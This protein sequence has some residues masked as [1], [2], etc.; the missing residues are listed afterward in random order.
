MGPPLILTAFLLIFVFSKAYKRICI[1]LILVVWV[2]AL[3]DTLSFINSYYGAGF[4]FIWE[5]SANGVS[6]N[7]IAAQFGLATFQTG[8]FVLEE[9]LTWGFVAFF[10]VIVGSIYLFLTCLMRKGG[11]LS[12]RM[13]SVTFTKKMGNPLTAAFDFESMQTYLIIGLVTMPS[14]IS[15]FISFS[16][17]SVFVQ[18][19][20][21]YVLLFYRFSLMA[22]TRL[23]KKADLH[24][25]KEDIGA[26][27]GKRVFSWFTQLNLLISIGL[28]GYTFLATTVDP[29]VLTAVT[30]QELRS[31]LVAILVL[32]F[33]EGFAVFFFSRFWH[34]WSRLRTRLS[35][36][37]VKGALYSLWRGMLIGGACFIL[38]YSMLSFVTAAT[39]F[40]SVGT[41]DPIF[42][43]EQGSYA[44]YKYM[45]DVY[46]HATHPLYAVLLLP[47][48]WSL[49]ALFLFQFIKVLIGG[50]L[51][52]RRNVA[53]EYSIVV[54]SLVMVILLWTVMP[55]TNF[56]LGTYSTGL[57]SDF[58][59]T[60]TQILV[61]FPL[62][63]SV[64]T[65]YYFV[66]A[67]TDILYIVF[68]D[69]PI[70]VFG[71]L[72]FAYFFEFRRDVTR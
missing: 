19:V 54:S 70:W 64:A 69:L 14:M 68:L 59:A 66:L 42:N 43:T 27:Y 48:L 39:T 8:A 32:P 50:S 71:S 31:L 30:L 29:A 6:D 22:Y 56:F 72:F 16:G 49:V 35:N 33:A 60:W 62:S 9:L 40:F 36:I 65:L 44:I 63:Q 45:N 1:T 15:I 21:Y 10:A 17:S 2:K 11:S 3:I 5:G 23:A 38:F 53:A 46:T 28:L 61:P 25:G 12:E 52:H 37:D 18:S 26:K 47:M 13:D 51:T 34:F 55:A 24:I 20:V 7:A 41:S 58:N 67:P 4:Y 57:A